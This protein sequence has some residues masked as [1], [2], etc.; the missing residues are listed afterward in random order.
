M[1]KILR[2][3]SVLIAMAALS[4]CATLKVPPQKLAEI[5]TIGVTSLL[6]DDFNYYYFGVLVLSNEEE[7][8]DVSDWHLNS[9]A[10]EKTASELAAHF[11][12]VSG[13]LLDKSKYD[14][15]NIGDFYVDQTSQ[16]I[17]AALKDKP[18]GVDA[19][20]L[21]IPVERYNFAPNSYNQISGLGVQRRL[22]GLRA[23]WVK[24]IR[25]Y[26][27]FTAYRLALF[28]ARSG[29]LILERMAELPPGESS[30]GFTPP[31]VD[32][33]D[34]DDWPTNF[35][36]VMAA[37]RGELEKITKETL[38]RSLSFT[39]RDMGLIPAN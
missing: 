38:T 2:G 9:F 34:S 36:E 27:L 17:F 11:K 20:L 5:K 31:F 14:G 8:A 10:S 22:L 26:V 1:L 25:R 35:K 21:L 12:I 30:L 23:P 28:D 32:V 7:S 37:H 29:E 19:Y 15:K 39:L 18:A 6:S 13:G 3:L 16:R 24:P 4:G 33:E